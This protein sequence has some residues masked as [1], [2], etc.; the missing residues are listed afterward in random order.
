ML[1]GNKEIK[2]TVEFL[3]ESGLVKKLAKN[4]TPEDEIII[5]WERDYVLGSGFSHVSGYL[6]EINEEELEKI[7]PNCINN[8]E[9]PLGDLIGRTG[10][11]EQYECLLR[12][13]N[14]EELV[15]VNTFG[16]KL[17][18][19]GRKPAVSG[20]SLKTTIDINLQKKVASLLDDKRGAI[21]V[22]DAH[23][24]VLE[25][26]SSPSYSPDNIPDYINNSDLPLFN[27]AIAGSFHPGSIFKLVTSIAALEENRIDKEL[28][29]F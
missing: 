3:P 8:A 12:G 21:I 29:S 26:Y 9:Y 7:D 4:E 27:R 2:N 20:R 22:T 15:E 6:G 13:T 28:S 10:L 25:L 16:E 17:R 18:T 14:G 24:E 23:G 19:L 5:E 1:V 11:E